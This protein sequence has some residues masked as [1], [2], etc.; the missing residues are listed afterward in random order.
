MA[1]STHLPSFDL[2][3][4]FSD[5][6]RKPLLNAPSPIHPLPRLS[7]SLPGENIIFAKREDLASPYFPAGNKLRKLE[8][9]IADAIGNGATHL[10]TVGGVQ[11]NH[12]RQV[13]SAAVAYG[14]KPVL[15]T[16]KWVEWESP[17]HNAVGNM[18]LSKLMGAEV[19]MSEDGFS[20]TATTEDTPAVAQIMMRVRE[21]GGTPYWIPAGASDHPLG[22]L[23]FARW[24]FELAA[25]EQE[26][27]CF[28]DTVI[29]CAVTG[30]TFAGMIA[31]FKLLEKRH[32]AQN[33]RV[34]GIDASAKPDETFAQVLKIARFTA[35]RIGLHPD[36]IAE[37]DVELVRGF[38]GPAYGVPDRST[39]EAIELGARTDAF[40]TDPIYEGK[41]LAG[42]VGLARRGELKGKRVLFAQLGGQV[43]LNAYSNMD[44]KLR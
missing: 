32:G 16:Q 3:H 29:V 36:D 43:A 31:G 39:L 19:V 23:G 1:L 33:R 34:I 9:L 35:D 26:T 22:G 10:V 8:Y 2:P 27:G 6:A 40:I 42:L 25:Q 18:Q 30:S 4:P 37:E 14:L 28:F 24:A 21:A 11:S 15:L 38:A 44:E 12:T 17:A 13:A 20:A 41:T 5:I 7:A